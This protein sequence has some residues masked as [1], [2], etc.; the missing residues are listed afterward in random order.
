MK[1]LIAICLIFALTLSLSGCLG[2]GSIENPRTAA[3]GTPWDDSWTSIGGRIGIE[4]PGGDFGLLD[5][6]GTLKSMEMYYATWV[7]GDPVEQDED[8]LVYDGQIYLLAED[9]GSASVAAD[10]MALWRE[11][12]GA[13]FT[14]TEERTVTAAG[15]EFTLV[16][17]DCLAE[18]SHF[19]RGVTAMGVWQDMGLLVDMA[20]VGE[21]DLDLAKTIEDFLNGFHYA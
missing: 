17:Y 8:T 19:S 11:Q 1:K 16:F 21:M 5:S 10:T 18:D 7:C 12:I 14:V 6:N 13:D 9:C 20:C 15:V 4:Q 3:D 2:D